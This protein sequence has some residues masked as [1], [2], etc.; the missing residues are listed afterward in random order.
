MFAWFPQKSSERKIGELLL[1]SGILEVRGSV[2]CFSCVAAPGDGGFAYV[3]SPR[4]VSV[5]NVPR[6]RYVSR[7]SHG[8]PQNAKIWELRLGPGNLGFPD[9]SFVFLSSEPRI[10]DGIAYLAFPRWALGV[11]VPPRG[12]PHRNPTQLEWVVFLGFALVGRC[13]L[14]R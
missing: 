7:N 4:W 12:I 9:W 14:T 1:E 2:F 10:Y 11:N 5:C 8:T 3:A 6:P 13:L